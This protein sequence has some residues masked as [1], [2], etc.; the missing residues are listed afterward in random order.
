[1]PRE[2]K[3]ADP[4]LVRAERTYAAAVSPLGSAIILATTALVVRRLADIVGDPANPRRGWRRRL[5]LELKRAIK[6]AWAT[7]TPLRASTAIANQ[8]RNVDRLNLAILTRKTRSATRAGEVRDDVLRDI[9]AADTQPASRRWGAGQADALTRSVIGHADRTRNVVVDGVVAASALSTIMRRAKKVDGM[10]RRALA[11]TA[12]NATQVLNGDFSEERWTH[13]HVFSYRWTTV[14]DSRV[15][16]LHAGR[17]HQIFS[18]EAP[19]SD[20]HPGQPV[21]CRCEAAPLIATVRP[22]TAQFQGS[23]GVVVKSYS[24]AEVQL[25]EKRVKAQVRTVPVPSL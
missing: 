5:D 25:I 8:R 9:A 24:P 11:N 14:G 13:A 22:A 7:Y 12:A 2:F 6:R 16:P 20:G 18:W 19:P 1:M 10:T 3:N 23:G 4:A 17:N 21:G 15:R